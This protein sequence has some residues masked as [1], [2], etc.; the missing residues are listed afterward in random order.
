MNQS[1]ELIIK[2]PYISNETRIGNSFNYLIKVIEQSNSCDVSVVWDFEDVVF[3]H[4]FFLAPLA[5]Y[6]ETSNK[7]ISC[8][9]MSL[10]LQSYFND[11]YFD[12]MLYFRDDAKEEIEAVMNDYMQKSYTPLCC[13]A[14]SETNKDT[15]SSVFRNIISKQSSLGIDS[16]T[17][18][19]YFISELLDNIYEHSFSEKGYIFAQYLENEN[20]LFLF[21]ADIGITVAGSFKNR[22]LFQSDIDG[23]DAVALRLANEG[24]STKN[25]PEAE[26]RG[27]GIST[28]KQMLVEGLGGSFFMISGGAFHRYERGAENYYANI[29]NLLYWPGTIVLLRIPCTIPQGF[30]YIDYLE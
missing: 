20:S 5:L 21:I 13:F 22:G 19:S 12:R 30:N 28:T 17:P 3:L 6:K 2:I 15:F 9:N 14:M 24:Y 18:L 25:R 26:N 8:I 1:E 27:Y 16:I 29:K 10:R 11:I 23:D 4:P 7:N